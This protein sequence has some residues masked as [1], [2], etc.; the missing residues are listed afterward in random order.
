VADQGG[1]QAGHRLVSRDHRTGVADEEL[2]VHQ[3]RDVLLSLGLADLV[4][5]QHLRR[6]RQSR[7]SAGPLEHGHEIGT[8]V[9][10]NKVVGAAGGGQPSFGQTQATSCLVEAGVGL[11]HEEPAELRVAFDGFGQRPQVVHVEP[12]VTLI[13]PA[14][15]EVKPGLRVDGAGGASREQTEGGGSGRRS[16]EVRH[17]GGLELAALFAV[18]FPPPNPEGLVQAR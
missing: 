5:D 16:A 18:R 11:V 4:V 1:D 10:C 7:S 15:L 6:G 13:P 3:L 14:R 2:V 8:L 17:H 12:A 9:D